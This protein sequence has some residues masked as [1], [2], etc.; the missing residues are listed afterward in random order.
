MHLANTMKSI[1]LAAILGTASAVCSPCYEKPPACTGSETSVQITGVTGDFCSPLCYQ[2]Q[3]PK[4]DGSFTATPSCVLETQGSSKPTQCALIC[5]PG[6]DAACPTGASCQSIQGEGICTY[7]AGSLSAS[8][9]KTKAPMAFAS[10]AARF[11]ARVVHESE[12][13]VGVT[14][15]W[16]LA[17]AAT[18]ADTV[19]AHIFLAH[20]AE[21]MAALDREWTARS[22]PSNP[23]YAKWLSAS[24]LASN[25][26]LTPPAASLAT[27]IDWLKSEG[28]DVKTQTK[29]SLTKDIVTVTVA[30]PLAAQLFGAK[31]SVFTTAK[32]S[33]EI[34]RVVTPYTLPRAV[35]AVV[36]TVGSIARFPSLHTTIRAPPSTAEAAPATW[37][38]GCGAKCKDYVTPEV[39][40]QAY[41]LGEAVAE[42]AALGSMAV[43]EFQN[44][45]Y[46]QMD[47]YY[48]RTACKL[49]FN[50]SVADMIGENEPKMC[51]QDVDGCLEALLDI[52]FIKGVAGGIPLTDVY[53][54]DYSLPGVCVC[55]CVRVRVCACVCG[56]SLFHLF[57]P[58]YQQVCNI[59]PSSLPSF[60]PSS[61][62]SSSRVGGTAPR[63]QRCKA[64]AHQ[65]RELR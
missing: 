27:V 40:T 32:A 46:D 30:A 39:L 22:D 57:V 51:R 26:E 2:N 3:C 54:A 4:G 41:S 25:A 49:P 19:S 13:A 9:T 17:R 65:Q 61:S 55:V 18:A 45:Y 21:Q 43:A 37:P 16:T 56:V 52:Q 6:D 58:S 62:S 24:N 5:T 1:S 59:V 36:S 38:A 12:L 63:S 34:T 33:A 47:M 35:A 8:A 31:F 60:L 14:S 28:V 29:T 64:P 7:P 20:T 50:V 15:S 53:S 48:F 42:G 44:V 11:G 10:I 23:N